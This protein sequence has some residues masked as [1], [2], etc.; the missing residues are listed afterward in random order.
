M[1][2]LQ[3]ILQINHMGALLLR[4][5]KHSNI[6]N[7]AAVSYQGCPWILKPPFDNQNPVPKQQLQT[8]AIKAET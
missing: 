8:L 5:K 2:H 6:K 1:L 7:D 3:C 4:K